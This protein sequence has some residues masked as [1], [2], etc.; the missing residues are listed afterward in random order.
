MRQAPALVFFALLFAL[1]APALTNVALTNVALT[2]VALT[3][4]ALTNV[5][6]AKVAAVQ[7]SQADMTDLDRVEAYLNEAVTM[8]ARFLQVAPNG[9]TSEG[10][11]YLSRPGKMRLEYDP[12]VPIL[13]ISDGSWLIYHDKELDQT[14]WLGLD[15][16]P[17]GILVRRNVKLRGEDVTVTGVQRQPGVL[18]ISVVQTK[19]PAAGEMSLIFTTQPFQL[20]QWRIRDGQGQI[21]TVS[22]FETRQGVN[23]DPKL[24]EFVDQKFFKKDF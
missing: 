14:S 20:R 7:L 5:A 11:F 12:P 3:N 1:A 13:V 4:V 2:N 24:F 19:D 8:K 17:A 15:S 18:V 10:S 16:T 23:L 22:L 9:G 6:W 21:T